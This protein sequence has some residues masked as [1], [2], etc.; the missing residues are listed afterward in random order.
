MGSK[1]VNIFSGSKFESVAGYCRAVRVGN[2]I[3]VA[4]TTAFSEGQVVGVNDVEKQTRF[5][6]Q[7]IQGALEKAGAGLK[8]VVRT[9]MFVT[10]IGCATEVCKI[11]KEFFGGNPPASTL[12]EVSKFVHPD[13]LIEVEVSAILEE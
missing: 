3:E 4:G 1:R 11:H 6:F 13:L 7:T 9:R 5:V 8:D 12:V 2:I 10:D